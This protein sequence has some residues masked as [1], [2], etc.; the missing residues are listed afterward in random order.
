MLY[1]LHFV[2]ATNSDSESYTADFY[3]ALTSQ[4]RKSAEIIVRWAISRFHPKSVVDVGCGSGEFVSQFSKLGVPKVLGVEGNWAKDIN[5]YDIP[6]IFHDLEKE[7]ILQSKFDLCMS[8]EVA[9]HISEES[10][11]T[12]VKSLINAADVIVFSAAIPGQGGTNHVNL[13]YPDYWAKMFY[14][15]GFLLLEDPRKEFPRKHLIAPWYR[16]NILVY[17]RFQGDISNTPIIIP[18]TIKDPIIFPSFF[19]IRFYWAR[20]R[21]LLYRLFLR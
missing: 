20:L 14:K 5:V 2:G 3:N 21:R 17:S 15:H 12:F 19:S 11:E 16:Q 13:Q 8:L 4:N 6:M 9:E 7:L 10:A 1:P 18:K